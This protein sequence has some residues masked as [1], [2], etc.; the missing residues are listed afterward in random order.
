M[1]FIYRKLKIL[2]AKNAVTNSERTTEGAGTWCSGSA[3]VPYCDMTASKTHWYIVWTIFSMTRPPYH[4][5]PGHLFALSLRRHGEERYLRRL[6]D[7]QVIEGRRDEE[8]RGTDGATRTSAFTPH[9]RKEFRVIFRRRS[10]KIIIILKWFNCLA[11]G[12]LNCFE[13]ST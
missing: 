1:H 5:T 10:K 12:R 7:L 6:D 8:E 4:S 9:H 3:G 13:N 11:I 2:R